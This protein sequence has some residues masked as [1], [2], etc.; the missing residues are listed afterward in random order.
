VER[1]ET[2][3][4]AALRELEEEAAIRPLVGLELRGVFSNDR[5]M[6][7]DHLAFYVVRQFE[8]KPF[9]PNLEI[10]DVQ[11]FHPQGLPQRMN[12]GTRRRIEEM[13]GLRP[14]SLHW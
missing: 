3:E 4:E 9:T 6:R 12:G 8:Q 5:E 7:G 11:F 10:A 14:T 2:C 1:G 13:E